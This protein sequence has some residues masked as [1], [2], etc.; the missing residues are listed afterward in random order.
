M[1]V[2]PS[3]QERCEVRVDAGGG[4][5]AVQEQ[6]R[7]CDEVAVLRKLVDGISSVAA[8]SVVSVEKGDTALAR[9]GLH[10]SRVVREAPGSFFESLDVEELV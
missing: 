10:E 7:G 8:H 2:T 5:V 3:P 1:Q 6:I 9:R 4:Q